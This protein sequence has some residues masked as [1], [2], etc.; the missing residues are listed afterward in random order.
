[1]LLKNISKAVLSVLEDSTIHG[2]PNIVKN[3]RIINKIM[4]AFVFSGSFGFCTYLIIN[5]IIV[6]LQYGHITNLETIFEQPSQFFTIQFC[7]K[8]AKSFNNRTLT[9]GDLLIQCVYNYDPDCLTNPGAYFES[10]TDPTYGPCFRFNS[11]KNMSGASIPIL[12]ST[13]GGKDDSFLMQIYAP[14]GLA[15]WIHNYTTPPRRQYQANN[16][17]DL[18]YASAGFDTQVAVDRTFYYKLGYPYNDCLHDPSTFKYNKTII[19]FMINTT[20]P[21]SQ[22]N[23]LNLCFNMH[24]L[25]DNPCNC[26]NTTFA[27][28]WTDCYG[29]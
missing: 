17:G 21:Y 19:D 14:G 10:Y 15:F 7:S 26:N 9:K 5:S 11:G 28:V 4:W 2:L 6:F 3:E 12:N 23:C 22:V 13:I 24:Y 18:Q 25:M 20:I 8:D 1:M 16:N 29:K 27:S